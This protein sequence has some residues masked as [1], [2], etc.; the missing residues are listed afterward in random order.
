MAR[1]NYTKARAKSL[2]IIQKFGLTANVTL[3]GT[4]GGMN[5]IGE[6]IADELD[7]VINGYA[8]PVLYYS[9]SS[10]MTKYEQENVI[11]GDGYMFFY[12]DKNKSIR[13]NSQ[14][15]NWYSYYFSRPIEGTPLVNM[16][17]EDNGTTWRVQAINELSSRDG[18]TVVTK[19]M[20]RR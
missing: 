7:I 10:T 11:A 18:V 8:S 19:V 13:E 17:H 14:V 4:I 2:D 20:L 16:T 3:K 9:S 1:F 5:A 6:T 15:K 12:Y